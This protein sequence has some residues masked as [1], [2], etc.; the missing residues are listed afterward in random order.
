MQVK[1][2]FAAG[3]PVAVRL[4]LKVLPNAAQGVTGGYEVRL[5][6]WS[7]HHRNG[8]RKLEQSES[9]EIL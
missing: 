5:H 6:A 4:K 1:E 9:T 7:P 8:L 3:S 2:L